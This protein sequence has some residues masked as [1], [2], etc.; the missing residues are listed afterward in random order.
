MFDNV[1]ISRTIHSLVGFV[2]RDSG[3]ANAEMAVSG[4]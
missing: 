4:D 2:R 3:Q 1:R